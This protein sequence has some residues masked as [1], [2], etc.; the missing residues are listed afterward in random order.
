MRMS[1]RNGLM[2][3]RLSA[4]ARAALALFQL[5]SLAACNGSP[6]DQPQPSKPKT[7]E[8]RI[9]HTELDPD[10]TRHIEQLGEQLENMKWSDASFRPVVTIT[11]LNWGD[12]A[13]RLF[14]NKDNPPDVAHLEPFMVHQVLDQFSSKDRAHLEPI[15]DVIEEIGAGQKLTIEPAL[16]EIHRY[17]VGGTKQLKTFGIAYAVGT[18]FIAYRRD[19]AP[20]DLER[21]TTWAGLVRFAKGLA[22]GHD[23]AAPFILPGKSPFFI[24]QL[25][26]EMVVSMGGSIYRE[27]RPNLAGNSEVEAAL[28]VLQDMVALT[29]GKFSQTTYTDQFDRFAEGAGAV[30]PVTYGRAT[31]AIEG[32]LTKKGMA[33][34][35]LVK[36]R[37]GFAVLPQPG[38]RGTA[39][40]DAEPWVIFGRKKDSPEYEF[41][42]EVAKRFLTLFYER[43][44]YLA[45]C[46]L[47]PVHLRPIFS[48]LA[49]EYEEAPEQVKWKE[50]AKQS[51]EMLAK[52]AG[53][54]PILMDPGSTR[55]PQPQFILDLQR[56]KVIF[57]MVK[58]A[59]RPEVLKAMENCAGQP[60]CAEEVRSRYIKQATAQGQ[61][62]AMRV[63]ERIV[64]H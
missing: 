19:W 24:D 33:G 45:F 56:D 62:H 17:E 37:S 55:V 61:A 6:P 39:T 2:P 57:D 4:L 30:V 28:R 41:R 35:A 53:T 29:G 7:I 16:S 9:W 58:V 1:E 31:K 32:A 25:F 52:P 48:E 40:I 36:A 54:A 44:S 51:Q 46:R 27:T 5:A 43:K 47:V 15:D 8:I 26:N 3:P 12:V 49:S 59:T 23:G 34:E 10:A 13:K 14:E 38:I 22:Q 42:L 63:Y 50:W 60:E 20:P 18:T 64:S 11:P 21:P